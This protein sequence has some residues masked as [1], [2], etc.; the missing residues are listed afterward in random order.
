[1]VEKDI[2]DAPDAPEDPRKRPYAKKKTT[3]A[4]TKSARKEVD[5]SFESVQGRL[6]IIKVGTV[7]H[8]ALDEDL[9]D[10]QE[11]LSSL[12]EQ[13]GVKS[14]LFVTHHAIDITVI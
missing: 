6:I 3:S 14:I 9:T 13:N 8:P 2:K 11:K 10:I 12:L 5:L 1:M 7:E 4:I